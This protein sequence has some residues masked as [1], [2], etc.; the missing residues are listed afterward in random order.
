MDA[1]Q[2]ASKDS[3]PVDAPSQPQPQPQP[4]AKPLS[5]TS[6]RSRKL[7]CD[8]QHPCRN[9]VRSGA[10]CIFP[11]RK[12]IQRPRKTKNSELLQRLNR[13]ESI[14]GK[15]G[16]ANLEDQL[17][18]DGPENAAI[19][20]DPATAPRAHPV[21]A[22]FAGPPEGQASQSRPQDSTASRYLSGEF[23]SS[24]CDEVGGLKQALEQSTDSDDDEP[25]AETT[26]E[27]AGDASV[28][29]GMLLGAMPGAR[30]QHVE[31]PSPEHIRYLTA[32]YFKNVDLLLKILHRP[33]ITV[34]LYQL[35]DSPETES[36][37]AP[38]RA[39]LF[40]SVYF[41][42]IS[43]LSLEECLTH[44]GQSRSD[45]KQTYQ[46][47]VERALA[48]ADYLNSTSLESLQALTLYA[49]CLRNHSG[50]SRSSWVLLS[51][52]IR[53]A[54]ALN[55]HRDG[56][57]SQLPPYEAELRRRLW[58]QLIVMDV[59]A[60]E[61]RGTMA[62]IAR[63]SYDTRLPHN[64]DDAE[65]GPESTVPLVDRAGPSDATFSLCTAQS[66]DIFLYLEHGQ[67]AGSA[68]PA[69][70]VEETIRHAQHLESQF[71]TG[72]DPS[73]KA[74]YLASVTVRLII[75]KLWLMLHYP[76]HGR[77]A[78]S[79]A[80]STS[81]AA[82]TSSSQ[83]PPPAFTSASPTSSTAAAAEATTTATA[84]APHPQPHQTTT[85][86]V[87]RESVL[88]LT[89]K[90][91]EETQQ[92]R[93]NAGAFAESFRWWRDTYVQWHP[94]AVALAELCA[95]PRG[96]AADRAWAVVDGVFPVSSEI[97][98]DTKRGT[99]WRPIRKLHKKARAAREAA[100]AVDRAAPPGL[101]GGGFTL[102]PGM[103]G[104]DLR[105]GGGGGDVAGGG[106]GG[107]GMALDPAIT[108]TAAPDNASMMSQPIVP[109]DL[110]GLN[111]D[112]APGAVSQEWP[113][114]QEWLAWPD[115]NFDIPS[116]NMPIAGTAGM[117]TM[118]WS[119]WDEFVLDTHA[120]AQSM[121]G[122]SEWS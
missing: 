44:L 18:G 56:D 78:K 49:C 31:H 48:R 93:A 21:V 91:L 22:G 58:W 109:P 107:D 85:A 3:S 99:L 69:Q 40:F 11:A 82:A 1:G 41:A 8:R 38:E 43:S 116:F 117:D 77:R 120:D 27:S 63:D 2:T 39:A 17:S 89:T 72:A 13:L 97:I 7:R 60:A 62:I 6:C 83:S 112:M 26:P 121:R 24:L 30:S 52:P 68:R 95:S 34:A 67:E 36:Q 105:P 88:R 5:C 61:D 122:S 29:P 10:D 100:L 66:S 54:Q 47:G 9:C 73:H 15:V 119:T 113:V 70:S 101:W 37:L 96:E 108:A 19:Q 98:A 28:Y 20:G 16:L 110:G 71:V 53:L 84:P 55:L 33:T 59:R 118:D 87:S 81:A 4:Q 51:L 25:S 14:V 74:S 106:G 65:F 57:G 12:R 32:T 86:P 79:I 102:Y 35:A 94:L 76:L 90:I 23:W 104:L 103:P 45:L 92:G 64:I 46:A 80:N 115:L 114:S 111:L 75:M 42:A 50:G